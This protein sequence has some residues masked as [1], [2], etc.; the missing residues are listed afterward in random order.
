MAVPIIT[1]EEF[2][3]MFEAGE[4]LDAYLDLDN[5]RRPGRERRAIAFDLPKTEYDAVVSAAANSGL[6]VADLVSTW[7]IERVT[8]NAA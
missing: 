2:D 8:N 1:G 7:V 3:R 4:D 5:I 6:K